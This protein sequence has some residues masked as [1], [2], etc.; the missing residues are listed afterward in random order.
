MEPGSGLRTERFQAA[1]STVDP[2]SADKRTADWFQAVALGFHDARYESKHISAV[3]EA[4][5]QD[6]RWLTGVYDDEAPE[7]AWNPA[8]PVATYATMT[9][10]L[11]TGGA[12]LPIHQITSVTVRPTHRRRGILRQMITSDLSRAK[13]EG[14]AAAALTASEAVIYGRFGFGVATSERSVEVDARG[15]LEL[16]VPPSGTAAVA[17]LA[18]LEALAPEIFRAHLEHTRGALGRQVG[19]AKRAAGL[20]GDLPEPEKDVRAAVH[21][22]PS[23][24]PDGYVSYKFL[25][26]ETEPHTL[27][28]L[29][30]VAADDTARLELWRYLGSI[31]LVERISQAAAPEAD[32]LPWAL[33]DRRRYAVKAHE[34]Q[35]WVRA[36]DP[37][38][39]LRARG[40][41]ADGALVLAITDPLDLAS[42]RWLVQ[43]DA[44]AAV[45]TA[46]SAEDKP[47]S[48]V[49][50]V[51]ADAAAFGS[52]YLGS[53]SAQILA[54]AGGIRGSSGAV[55]ALGRL[56]DVARAPYCST[57][58]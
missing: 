14:F 47:P 23:G 26:W 4:Y 30:L 28:V 2:G 25:P 21:Y 52:L 27:K 50:V 53:V 24:T 15:R 48:G 17:D 12:L 41:D 36:L 55:E 7:Y 3:V 51:E 54:A 44:G 31:D 38:A 16:T 45:V 18:K 49:P 33:A 20:W 22:D 1:L 40:F 10:E 5:G 34:D 57:H 46:L 32:P 29:D 35:L 58:F 43:V 11:N 19:Y 37:A 8:A 56:F 9:H 42:G 13:D 6:G 39:M